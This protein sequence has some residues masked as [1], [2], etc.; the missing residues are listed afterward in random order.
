MNDL[1]FLP[2]VFFT[3]FC[4]VADF[5]FNKTD[6]VWNDGEDNGK[7]FSNTLWT[8]RKVNNEC[9]FVNPGN[10]FSI[11]AR[12]ASGVTSLGPTPVP[13]AV[14]MRSALLYRNFHYR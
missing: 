2:N 14:T 8:S 12:V 11:T 9:L 4:A 7:V 3:V 10:S 1:G 13:P 6:G 5:A